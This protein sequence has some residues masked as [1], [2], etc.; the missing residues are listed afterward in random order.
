MKICQ[1]EKNSS[2]RYEFI[3]YESGLVHGNEKPCATWLNSAKSWNRWL[4]MECSYCLCLCDDQS[5]QSDRYFNL[6]PVIADVKNNR[7]V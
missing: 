5:P 4:F 3:K 1:A 6:R 2:R 7:L